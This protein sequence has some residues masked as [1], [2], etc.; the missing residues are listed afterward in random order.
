M[1]DAED[2]AKK[3]IGKFISQEAISNNP[4]KWWLEN[5]K[6]FS[7]LLRLARKYLCVPATSVLSER[8]FSIA[9]HVVNAKTT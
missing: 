8:A 9:G 5:G 1:V 6:Y 2:E 7:Q 3:E 4:L